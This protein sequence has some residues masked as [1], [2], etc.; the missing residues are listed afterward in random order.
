VFWALLRPGELEAP[1]E[2]ATMIRGIFPILLCG[3]LSL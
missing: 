3:M 1:D 2:F